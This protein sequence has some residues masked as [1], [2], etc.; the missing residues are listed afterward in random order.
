MKKNIYCKFLKKISEKQDFQSYPGNLG[1]FIYENISKKAWIKWQNKQTIMI[2]E[3]KL[4]M[5][6]IAHRKILE[7]KMINFLFKSKN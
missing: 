3:N 1:R 2:N 6:N 7:N 5:L 4:N